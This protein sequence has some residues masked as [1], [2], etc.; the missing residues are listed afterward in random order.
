MSMSLSVPD[1]I[2]ALLAGRAVGFAGKLPERIGRPGVVRKIGDRVLKSRYH[3]GV[4][5]KILVSPNLAVIA[6]T[7]VWL[8]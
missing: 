5:E 6:D 1:A 2:K 3:S 7:T 8:A 4:F